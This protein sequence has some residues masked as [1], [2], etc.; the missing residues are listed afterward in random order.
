MKQHELTQ[1]D[2]SWREA[3]E[4]RPFRKRLI[5]AVVLM[6]GVLAALPPFFQVIE[7]RGGRHIQD[8]LLKYLGPADV[9]VPIFA[10][11]WGVVLLGIR[12]AVKSPRFVYLFLGSYVPLTLLRMA[13]IY[14]TSLEPPEGLIPLVDPIANRFYGEEFV[15]RDLFFS[16]HTA[17]VFLFAY[18]LPE[19]WERWL[20][21]AAGTA[22]GVLVLVQHVHYSI[23]VLAAPFLTYLC[24]FAAKKVLFD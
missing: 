20:A 2:R 3:W 8:P 14:M 4:D 5:V 13:T 19:K 7:A 16:G 18:C 9:S 12:R 1:A 15:T 23:D 11:I 24:Y 21:A 10:C 17:T 22:V 6:L